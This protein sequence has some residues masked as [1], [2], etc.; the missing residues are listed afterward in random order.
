MSGPRYR[1]QDVPDDRFPRDS[2][3]GP[4]DPQRRSAPRSARSRSDEPTDLLQ[5]WAARP[6]GDD[7]SG[8]PRARTALPWP[9]D[10]QNVAHGP[11]ARSHGGDAG[12]RRAAPSGKPLDRPFFQRRLFYG[13]SVFG[14]LIGMLITLLFVIEQKPHDYAVPPPVLAQGS[15]AVIMLGNDIMTQQVTLAINGVQNRIPAKLSDITTYLHA[16]NQIDINATASMAV[17][18][19]PISLIFSPYI[20]Q[21]SGTVK[22][23]L[24]AA[25]LGKL[26]VPSLEAAITTGINIQLAK[27]SQGALP[28][29]ISYQ[30]IDARVTA[31][32]LVITA[33]VKNT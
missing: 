16:N 19:A 32:A 29:G 14:M 7:Q 2:R 18:S 25:N 6:I 8:V 20:D 28:N 24:V 5:T 9:G 10:R 27:L 21:A 26:Q 11:A 33:Q 17:G 3:S 4:I 23:H 22:V 31:S 15:T 12:D 13:S 30:I 1:S